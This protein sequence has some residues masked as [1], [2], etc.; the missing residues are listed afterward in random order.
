MRKLLTILIV[1]VSMGLSA[2]DNNPILGEWKF[3]LNHKIDYDVMLDSAEANNYD[4]SESEKK[5]QLMLVISSTVISRCESSTIFFSEYENKVM[6]STKRYNDPTTEDVQ[7]GNWK[8]IDDTK[9][10]IIFKN[11]NEL[12]EYNEELNEFYLISEPNKN[13]LIIKLLEKNLKMVKRGN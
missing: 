6:L 1:F 9:Y 10:L 3:A 5:L 4:V 8:K 11:R 12:Y 2:Q 7:W 13:V